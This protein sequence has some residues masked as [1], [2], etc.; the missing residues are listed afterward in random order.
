MN[1]LNIKGLTKIYKNKILALDKIDLTVKEGDFFGLIGANGAGKTTLIGIITDLVVKTG[2]E[3]SIF[4]KNIETDF[5]EAKKFIGAV[6]QEINFNIFE[7]VIDILIHQAGFYGISK[8]IAAGRTERYLK[9]LG[10]WDKRHT[11]ANS[12]SGGMKK[13]LMIARSLIHEPKLLILDEPTAGVD[14]SLRL[15]MWDFLKALNKEGR[16]IILTTHYLEEAEYLCRNIAIIN[17]GKIIENGSTKE[18]LSKSNKQT[19]IFDLKT[20]A[21]VKPLNG[22]KV[23]QIDDITIEVEMLKNQ[24]I[25]EVVRLLDKQG[26]MINSIR[27]KANRLEELFLSLV[28][29]ENEN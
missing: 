2:G 8:N 15:E 14:V 28:N 16:T 3:V 10:L 7:K 21:K 11:K 17:H 23:D 22:Y 19:A 18:L 29:N 24:T 5:N 13:R 20:P 1:A 9:Q 12:L 4:E 25:N 27:N 26:I 6:P